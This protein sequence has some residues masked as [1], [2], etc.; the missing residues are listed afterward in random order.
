VWDEVATDRVLVTDEMADFGTHA[1]KRSSGLAGG[2][3]D[4]LDDEQLRWLRVLVVDG[5]E[6]GASSDWVLA[7]A[8]LA[9]GGS[10]S[11]SGARPRDHARKR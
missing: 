10:A 3:C 11:G 8:S 4:T 9:S 5:C 7:R 2:L 1:E 6:C